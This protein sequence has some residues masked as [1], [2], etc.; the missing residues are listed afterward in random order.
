MRDLACLLREE[1]QRCGPIPF[2]QF[3]EAALYHPELGYYC[4]GRDPFGTQGDYYT[5]EQIQPTFG[6]LVAR[7]VEHAWRQL[8]MPA[9]FVVVELG[10]GRREM[11]PFLG[12]WNYT[13][14]DLGDPLPE[15][16]TG[17]VLANEFFDALPV[18][19]VVR[20]GDHWHL[21]RVGCDERRFAWVEAEEASSELR[22]YLES[23]FPDAPEGQ[24][25]EVCLE[26]LRWVE[27]ISDVLRSGCLLVIDYGY[28]ARE[29]ARFPEGTLMSY[30]RHRADPD[31]LQDPG[32]KDIT[33]HVC[34]TA[35]EQHLQRSGF[36][37]VRRSTLRQFLLSLG[38]SDA[39]AF[40]LEGT[41]SK[42]RQHRL[43]QLKTLLFGMGETFQVIEAWKAGG[44]APGE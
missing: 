40:L 18:D 36:H 34:F 15:Q 33:A 11:K 8:G 23:F 17:L 28:T 22:D 25:L 41:S 13:G 30:R 10:P 14:V 24:I 1:I 2:R 38:E 19:V 29:I 43:L 5:A 31:V 27:R 44:S 4:R 35:L 26:A 12:R 42:E 9:G 3:M 6:L 21:R 39:F 7:F 37:A 16:I 20:R 32:E